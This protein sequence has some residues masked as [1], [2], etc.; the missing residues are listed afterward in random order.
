MQNYQSLTRGGNY[1][2]MQA[3]EALAPNAF[4]TLTFDLQPDDQII[5]PGKRL[6][7]ML[8]SSDREFS[9]WPAPGTVLTFDLSQTSITL[10]IVGGVDAWRRAIPQP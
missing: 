8:M 9:L 6:A 1:E 3:S 5:P 2:S 7:L 10:P 4:Y